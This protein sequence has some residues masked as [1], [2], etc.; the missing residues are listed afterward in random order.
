MLGRYKNNPDIVAMTNLVSAY[1]RHEIWE[2]E[3]ILKGMISKVF[4]VLLI[5]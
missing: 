4:Y 3:K 2:F 5:Y 1:Q